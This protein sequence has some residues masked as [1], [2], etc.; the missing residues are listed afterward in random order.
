M[1]CVQIHSSYHA[2]KSLQIMPCFYLKVIFQR[3]FLLHSE[4]R[5]ASKTMQVTH[6]SKT[7]LMQCQWVRAPEEFFFNKMWCQCCTDLGALKIPWH[8]L[9]EC[10]PWPPWPKFTSGNCW[11]WLPLSFQ[12]HIILLPSHP[13]LDCCIVLLCATKQQLHFTQWGMQAE[14]LWEKWCYRNVV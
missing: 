4:G 8:F 12:L 2:F 3:A 11:H 1:A 6:H 13:V 7:E 10:L 5:S 14:T 9:K